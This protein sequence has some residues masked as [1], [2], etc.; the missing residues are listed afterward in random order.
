MQTAYE[1][2]LWACDRTSNVCNIVYFQPELRHGAR[3]PH[4]AVDTVLEYLQKNY[5]E[6]ISL[7]KL[8]RVVYLNPRYLCTIVKQDTGKTVY[9]HLT[10]IRIE[11][12][13]ELLCD[14]RRK[15]HQIAQMIGFSDPK[16]FNK[17]FKRATGK[18]QLVDRNSFLE[19]SSCDD[20]QE[21]N[22]K[23]RAEGRPP[24]LD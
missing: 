4:D 1:Q 22:E 21:D 12:A 10:N 14:P 9:E 2:A 23:I 24:D 20:G 3:H 16:I 18:K 17:T 8:S 11:K 19:C 5:A 15:M 7:D 6:P 13:C